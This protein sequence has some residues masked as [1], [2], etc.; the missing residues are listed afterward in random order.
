MNELPLSLPTAEQ[1]TRPIMIIKQFKVLK[2]RK[3][4]IKTSLTYM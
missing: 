2:Q 4:Y 1:K 3:Y